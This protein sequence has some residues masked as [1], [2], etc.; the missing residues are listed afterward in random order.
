MTKL[1]F[2]F[3]SS[4]YIVL[5]IIGYSGPI[6]LN[7]QIICSALL[8]A[9]VGIPHGAIDHIIYLEENKTK[10]FHFYLSY[11]T[12]MGLYII[13]WIFLP[14]A[15]LLF[16]LLLSAY[17][18]GESQ[19][20]NILD[21]DITTKYILPFTWGCSLLSGLV[22]YNKEEVLLLSKNSPDL[23]NL[24]VIFHWE[25]YLLILLF[26]TTITIMILARLLWTKKIKVEQCLKEIYL[27]VLIHSSFYVLPL[28]LGFTLYFVILHS[29]KV[30]IDEF[31]YLKI[32]KQLSSPLSFVKLLF[33]YTALSILGAGLLLYGVY[34]E[35]INVSYTFIILVFISA[36][37]LP[38]SI[39]MNGFYRR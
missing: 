5:S 30:L 19:F 20:S 3:I 21:R 36:L 34:F 38:H 23:S 12:L 18:F 13:C 1:G 14:I 8:I 32:K 35:I 22:L 9:V 24:I 29:V 4:L 37:T 26:S 10:P 2:L 16:F 17:H 39:V 15:S 33:P 28:L 11:F 7:T 27:L 31:T 25:L 6:D